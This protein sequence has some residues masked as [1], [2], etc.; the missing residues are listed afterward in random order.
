[1]GLSVVTG[2]NRGIGLELCRRLREQGAAVAAV[3]RSRSSELDALGVRVIDGV[4]VTDDAGVARLARELGDEPV[5]LLINN[6]G[7]LMRESIEDLDFDRVRRQL[8]ANALG[9][10][11]VTKAL[12]PKLGPGSKVAIITSR[13]GSIGDNASG[14]YYGYR[15]S[16]AAVNAAGRSLAHDLE[17]R[18]IA[19]VILHPGFVAT[20]MTNNSGSVAPE[21][22]A[23]D[24]L[25]RIGELTLE[26][27]GRF[28][29]ANGEELPW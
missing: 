22:A 15:M 5:D 27:T 6:A 4:D 9:P 14:G 13:M 26:K 2:A 21:D 25:A 12:L 16:K 10:L 17:P 28:L 1:M 11:R 23:R 8:E 29:H 24:L 3:C 18:R 19:V 7:I 20:D